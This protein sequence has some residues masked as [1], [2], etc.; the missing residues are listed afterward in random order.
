ML[1]LN[2]LSRGRYGQGR[3]LFPGTRISSFFATPFLYRWKMAAK[4][5]FLM[6]TTVQT[7]PQENTWTVQLMKC[8]CSVGQAFHIFSLCHY[9]QLC[10]QPLAALWWSSSE[11]T[12]STAGAWT[13]SWRRSLVLG[14][15]V[16][17]IM[18]WQIGF[19]EEIILYSIWFISENIYCFNIQKRFWKHLKA[20]GFLQMAII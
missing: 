17:Y 12:F 13:T 8:Y 20:Y 5:G 9:K 3:W 18:E 10:G 7:G 11:T 14:W 6:F 19:T 2:L 16:K 15:W 1:T 4:A